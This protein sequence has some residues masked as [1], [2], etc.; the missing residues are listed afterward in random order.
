MFCGHLTQ[1]EKGR[2]AYNTTASYAVFKGDEI[3]TYSVYNCNCIVLQYIFLLKSVSGWN[4]AIQASVYLRLVRFVSWRVVED[5]PFGFYRK[6]NDVPTLLFYSPTSIS[7]HENRNLIF[8]IVTQC[9]GSLV[10]GSKGTFV[11]FFKFWTLSRSHDEILKI[12]YKGSGIIELD[13]GIIEGY[14]EIEW[15]T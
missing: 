9:M 4:Y 8:S 14:Q 11:G 12:G 5:P 13:A 7:R 1:W 2:I 10:H 6:R 3:I 15:E